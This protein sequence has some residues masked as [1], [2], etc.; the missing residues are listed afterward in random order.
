MPHK[1]ETG[2]QASEKRMRKNE[3]ELIEYSPSLERANCLTH[4]AGAVFALI[5]LVPSL[6]KTV[7]SGSFRVIACAAVYCAAFLA[8]YTIS[9]VYHG[10]PKGRAKIK[11]RRFDHIAIPL[12]LA[13]TATPCSMISLFRVSRAHAYAVFAI[14]WSIALLGVISKLFFFGNNKLKAVSMAAYF[15][16]GAAM[17]LIAVPLLGEINREA[18]LILTAGCLLY[19][20]GALCCLIGTKKPVFHPVFHVFV[21]LGSAVQFYVLYTRVF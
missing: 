20:A 10:L 18:F 9:A 15:T 21:L 11:A 1:A 16:G 17:M 3:V 7:P 12:L 14:A 19:C 4:A 13:G 6:V 8:V 2:K 5:C